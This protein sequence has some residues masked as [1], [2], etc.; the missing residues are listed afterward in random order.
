MLRSAQCLAG[1]TIFVSLAAP[2]LP[3]SSREVLSLSYGINSVDVDGDGTLDTITRSYLDNANNNN[4]DFFEVMVRR[5]SKAGSD[6]EPEW[7]LVPLI[8]NQKRFEV[9]SAQ[10][11]NCIQSD[12]RFVRERS[13]SGRMQ[14]FLYLLSSDDAANGDHFVLFERYKFRETGEDRQP[15]DPPLAFVFDRKERIPSKHCGVQDASEL[16]QD[17]SKLDQSKED[18]NGR[19]HKQQR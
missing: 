17:Q 15:G 2:A 6:G 1:F 9:V 19:Q 10:V 7:N 16:L 11:G 5:P 8:A 13:A 18:T 4:A 14:I 3:A 12:V